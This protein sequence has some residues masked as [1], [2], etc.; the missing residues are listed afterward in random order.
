MQT[1]GRASW[2]IW[3]LALLVSGPTGPASGQEG[4]AS[5][6]QH[7]SGAVTLQ[8]R[9]DYRLAAE[10]WV[11]FIDTFKTDS[12][13]DR[14]FHYLGVCYLKT[15]QLDLARQCFEI[16]VKY[17]PKFDLLDATYYCLGST[18]YNMGQSGKAELYDAAADAFETVIS[19]YPQSE[20]VSQALFHRGECFYHRGKKQEAAETYS[21]WLAKFPG[22]KL[23]AEVLHALGVSQE[24]L[25]QN[26][27]AGKS[28]DQF[29]EKYP[30]NSLAAEVTVRRAALLAQDRKYAQAAAL[31][32]SV[33][34][35][36]PQS[37][38]LPVAGLAGGKCYY[39]AG[40]FAAAQKLLAQI[41]AADGL[42]LGEAA[43]WLVR[44]LLKEGEPAEAAATAA[45]LLPKL[46]GDP[47]AARLSMDRA[48]AVYEVPG[49]RGESV[50]L[51]AAIAT[52]Y[53][54]ASMAPEALYLAGFTALGQGD[55]PTALR[56]AAAYLAAYPHGTWVAEATYVEAESRLQLG[57]FAQAEK[58]F[59]ELLQKYP[60]GA[61]AETWQVRRG[62]SLYLQKKYAE[63]T[64][65]LQPKLAKLHA[66]DALAEANYLVGSSQVELKQF[67]AAAKSLEASLA[68]GPKWRQADQALLLLAQAEG[69]LHRGQQAQT[70]LRRLVAEFPESQV[71]DR[72]HYRLGELAYAGG[73]LPAA[74]AEYQQ[75]VDRWPQSSLVPRALYGLGWAKLSQN[76]YPSAERLFDTML[77]KFPKDKLAPRARY[78][79][80][81]ARHQRKDF[82][83][84]I[85][86]VQALL[87]ADP[88]PA[89]KSDARYLLG[90]CQTGLKQHAEAAA[91]FQA[92]L[93]DDPKYAGADKV[94]YELA[95]ALKQ[96][97]QQKEA[98]EVFSRLA[99]E[100]ADSPLAAESQY[101]LGESAY[102]SGQYQN[103]VA[104]Y[105][106][107]L[108]KAGR[109]AWGEKVAHK[110]GWAYFRLDDF[111]GAQQAFHAQRTTW[112]EGPL[113]GDAAFMEAESLAKQRKFAEALATYEQVKNPAGQDLPML[114]L[115]HAGQAAGEL[116]QWEKS[117]EWLTKCVAQFPE[118]PY[119]PEALCEQAWAQQN[120]GQLDE[121]L[122]LYQKVIA[123]T[124]REAAARSQFGIGEIQFQQKKYVEA[125][126]SFFKVAYGYSYPR[127]QAE[128]T[129]Q[130]GR[131][132]EA[133]GMK[134]EAIKQYRE[135][136]EKYPQSDQSPQAKQR[137][138]ELRK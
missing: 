138:E 56:H 50:A 54:K 119:V 92:I 42:S 120:L 73:D 111:A 55:Y 29:L 130:S 137:I 22:D 71:L 37:K 19:K 101:H 109:G 27:E 65:W 7:Y 129:Y 41:V 64:G 36:W 106:A 14:A 80:G 18:L 38:L 100:H 30:K 39:L 3:F 84:A 96:Q 75:V 57:Q 51:Y 15:N 136:L 122:A 45:R 115:L 44:S 13:C 40:N 112:P 134:E 135:L 24:E 83:P 31:Y 33:S 62:L 102:Q 21:Q 46:A 59:G 82:G 48:D 128:A 1:I 132:F 93:H 121:A 76:D 70:A 107:A 87:A 113:S 86:D 98:G 61:D 8:N 58:C 52:Q 63:T 116:K 127:W 12:R 97:D 90:L 104:A 10:Q 68:A 66:P 133:L 6:T 34:A 25:G 67:G 85:D 108:P 69:E 43:H 20:L 126:K 35:K 89:E 114:A 9:G 118:S 17:Y 60:A 91:S 81:I 124:G 4:S 28:Y 32:A 53:P 77:G 103:A 16:V 105:R 5:A 74:T 123:G 23:A 49:R 79:R 131:C 2:R 117:R 72:A 78:A 110:L 125:K 47:Q 94:L 95:W 99:A 11:K 88:T 26:A